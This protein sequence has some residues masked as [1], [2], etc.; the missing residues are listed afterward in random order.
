M[1][2]VS[3][4]K[5]FSTHTG[6][7]QLFIKRLNENR[8]PASLPSLQEKKDTKKRQVVHVWFQKRNDSSL[9]M[10]SK[11]ECVKL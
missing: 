5:K 9:G 10:I 2:N 4:D 7:K 6:T 8:L 1:E 3:I 11:N